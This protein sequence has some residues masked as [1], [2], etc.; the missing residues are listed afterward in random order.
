[1]PKKRLRKTNIKGSLAKIMLK[2][3]KKSLCPTF[4]VINIH[5][6][7]RVGHRLLKLK[8]LNDRGS[9]MILIGTDSAAQ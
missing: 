8:N 5:N 9:D 3:P 7:G 2:M 4:L 1:M 6:L